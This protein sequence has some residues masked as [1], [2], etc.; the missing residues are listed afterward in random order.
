MTYKLWLYI[1]SDH[2][3]YS[4]CIVITN[5]NY[6]Y[7]IFGLD[8]GLWVIKTKLSLSLPTSKTWPN[9]DAL[10][11]HFFFF[12]TTNFSLQK[13]HSVGIFA[14]ETHSEFRVIEMSFLTT[15]SI[16][17]EILSVCWVNC[18]QKR[19]R[20]KRDVPIIWRSCHSFTCEVGSAF[21]LWGCISQRTR[22][23][24]PLWGHRKPGRT[25]S[26][27]ARRESRGPAKPLLFFLEGQHAS[28]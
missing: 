6:K 27:K 5:S 1:I 23:A 18:F 9:L 13:W 10:F 3:T 7:F 20:D 25:L 8:N 22:N 16:S 17:E 19:E 28:H 4:D 24:F 11:S 15:H 26:P 2:I 21:R 12:L 14:S